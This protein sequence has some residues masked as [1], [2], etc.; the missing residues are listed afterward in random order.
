MLKIRCFRE[1]LRDLEC[2]DEQESSEL[3]RSAH[4]QHR[5]SRSDQRSFPENDHSVRIGRP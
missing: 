5:D 1:H 3:D 4:R 2:R